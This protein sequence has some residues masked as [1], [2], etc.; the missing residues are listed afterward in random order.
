[1]AVTRQTFKNLATNFIN[2]TFAD[3]TKTFTIEALTN[4]P[5]GQGGYVPSWSTFAT[6]T[7]FVQKKS[8]D[9]TIK[10]DQLDDNYPTTF[11]FKYISG[12]TNEMRVLFNGKYYNIRSIISVQEVD[13]WIDIVADESDAT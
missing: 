11:S 13:V 5:D 7:G 12:I 6:I 1:M 3:F 2:S 10:D 4:T 8:G 9:E